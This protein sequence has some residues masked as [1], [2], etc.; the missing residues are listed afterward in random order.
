MF[1]NL[2]KTQHS[3]LL[4]VSVYVSG[5]REISL[6]CMSMCVYK[7]F[8]DV[9]SSSCVYPKYLVYV[10]ALKWA[11]VSV[12]FFLFYKILLEVLFSLSGY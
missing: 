6:V 9:A 2:R 1:H 11:S 7:L 10:P 12:S 3:L 5:C 8:Q 4:V